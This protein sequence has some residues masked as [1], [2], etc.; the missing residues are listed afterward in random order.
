MNIKM[1]AL[2]VALLLGIVGLFVQ[3]K[4]SNAG[5][6]GYY[7]SISSAVCITSSTDME[8][9]YIDVSSGS[10]SPTESWLVVADTTSIYINTGVEPPANLWNNPAPG[11]L[12]RWPASKMISPPIVL[13]ST[14]TGSQV[15]DYWR[16]YDFTDGRGNGRSIREA[17]IIM[18]GGTDVGTIYTVTY[19][20]NTGGLK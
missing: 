9:L 15:N 5:G 10:T 17:L 2:Y 7:T 11:N 8:L 14:A 18:K 3:T 19:R 4:V 20:K 1:K 13:F 6:Y 16:R 12:G